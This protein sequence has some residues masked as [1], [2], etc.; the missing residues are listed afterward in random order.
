MLQTVRDFWTYR[1][2]QR[3]GRNDVP[4]P[5]FGRINSLSWV[6]TLL[7]FLFRVTNPVPAVNVGDHNDR[8]CAWGWTTLNVSQPADYQANIKRDRLP[9]E[10]NSVG[11]LY[12]SHVLEHLRDHEVRHFL[13][14]ACRT[15]R[16]G[17]LLRIVVPDLDKYV[18]SFQ[19]DGCSLHF[20]RPGA[21]GNSPS[22]RDGL[23]KM[24]G[25]EEYL[26]PHNGLIAAVASYTNGTPPVLV[27]RELF[28][29]NFDPEHLDQFV[30]WAVS[31]KHD[32]N[33]EDFGH[34]NAYNF[35]RMSRLLRESGFTS[36]SKG[37]FRDPFCSH[38]IS[39]LDLA[40]KQMI[41][42]YVNAGKS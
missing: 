10:D 31:L 4:S 22:I 5:R 37:F 6:R 17:G 40:N 39:K 13:K 28:E 25:D 15:L 11:Y 26:A 12:A 32:E 14:E 38:R 29:A 20:D 9:F 19:E 42:L 2:D 30:E 18:R 23:R 1:F 34:F 36:V 41:S 3:F 33:G 8:F 35:I 24:Y 27:S 16:P 7:R 21:Y